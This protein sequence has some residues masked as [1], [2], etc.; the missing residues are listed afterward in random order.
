MWLALLKRFWPYIA[1]A[2]L[3]IVLAVF[4]R[5][6]LSSVEQR[7]YDRAKVEYAIELERDRQHRRE[8][9]EET[10]RE[11]QAKLSALQG[12][13]NK[14]LARRNDAIRMCEPADQVRAGSDPSESAGGAGDGSALRSGPDLQPRLVLYGG[15]CEKLRQ[16][17]ID[18]KGRQAKR[19]YP[20]KSAA[21]QRSE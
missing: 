21:A 8:V 9:D 19:Q 16:Q 14:L 5:G 4:V 3:L 11:H 20:A 17:L 1:G 10:E 15:R 18:I 7:G 12:R 6:Y 2:L 13:V